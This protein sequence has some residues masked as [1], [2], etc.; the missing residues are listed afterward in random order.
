M[1]ANA[2]VH[3][4]ALFPHALITCLIIVSVER[5]E[6]KPASSQTKFSFFSSFITA[7]GTVAN[8][9]RLSSSL[10]PTLLMQVRAWI[11]IS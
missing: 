8:R 7:T 3:Y 2:T 9:P 1:F 5:R 6:D 4:T 10:A 11:D